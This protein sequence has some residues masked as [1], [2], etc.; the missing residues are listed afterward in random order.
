MCH[1]IF[2]FLPQVIIIAVGDF[3]LKRLKQEIVISL[4]YIDKYKNV[5]LRNIPVEG[6]EWK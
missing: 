1:G 6:E 3:L 4:V 2:R 5:T